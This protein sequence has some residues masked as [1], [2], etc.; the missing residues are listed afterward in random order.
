M[1]AL[2]RTEKQT[3]QPRIDEQRDSAMP[4]ASVAR[5]V[6]AINYE[7]CIDFDNLNTRY[8]QN[9]FSPAFFPSNLITCDIIT[10]KRYFR[11]W[12]NRSISDITQMH[13]NT[14]KCKQIAEH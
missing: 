14:R 13:T 3:L 9:G 8:T 4:F 5:L 1:V 11:I 2:N 12:C 7:L 6:S 10:L